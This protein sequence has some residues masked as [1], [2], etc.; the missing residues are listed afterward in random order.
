M[1]TTQDC[2]RLIS[3]CPASLATWISSSISMSSLL[4]WKQFGLL[5]R[6]GVGLLLSTATTG[7]SNHRLQMHSCLPLFT[8]QQVKKPVL[9]WQSCLFTCCSLS[10]NCCYSTVV[11]HACTLAHRLRCILW[12][13]C[14]GCCATTP[15]L[16]GWADRKEARL[17]FADKQASCHWPVCHDLRSHMASLVSLLCSCVRHIMRPAAVQLCRQNTWSS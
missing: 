12:L 16:D 14:W 6:L 5:I 1:L 3:V 4:A 9:C 7:Y 13:E 2:I 11:N 10:C 8:A 15:S 17:Y